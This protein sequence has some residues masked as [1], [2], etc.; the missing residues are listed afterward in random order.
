MVNCE[1]LRPTH[2]DHRI[3]TS[4]LAIG[5]LV[6][7]PFVESIRSTISETSTVQVQWAIL[8]SNSFR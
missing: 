1:T 3:L 7:T 8:S 2:S 5:W 4:S 6:T